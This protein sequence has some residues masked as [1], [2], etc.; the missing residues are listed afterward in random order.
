METGERAAEH[1]PPATVTRERAHPGPA[2]YVKVAIVLAAV[3]AI[4]V[5][6]FYLDMPDAA[7]IGGLLVLSLVK[8]S[9]VVL[10]F[11]HLRFDSL[12][13]RRLFIAGISLALA[14]YTIV[15][16][17]LGVFPRVE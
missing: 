17:S 11:M 2:E 15:L 5:V 13:F 7:L 3:T 4:E 16:I 14:V 6:L 9:L 12:L 10:W 8:F 1:H